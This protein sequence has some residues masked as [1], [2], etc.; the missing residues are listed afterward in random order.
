M[1]GADLRLG[2]PLESMYIIQGVGWNFCESSN[3][4]AT[5]EPVTI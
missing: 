2:L 3:L 4:A 1:E 5:G